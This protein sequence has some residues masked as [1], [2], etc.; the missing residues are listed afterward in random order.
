ML[1]IS[2][3]RI[4]IP[5]LRLHKDSLFASPR[6]QQVAL[7]HYQSLILL[8]ISIF[9]CGLLISP[10]SRPSLGAE[11][12]RLSVSS[13]PVSQQRALTAFDFHSSL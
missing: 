9:V 7:R 13:L 1:V 6:R 3:C 12:A 4:I 11:I 8:F 2:T 10:L 5:L